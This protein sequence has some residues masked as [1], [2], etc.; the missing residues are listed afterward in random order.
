MR[1]VMRRGL[2]PFEITHTLEQ[3]HLNVIWRSSMKVGDLVRFPGWKDVG[4][5]VREIPG[6]GEVKVVMWS[7]SGLS[8]HAAKDLEVINESR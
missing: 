5:I 6:W 1:L 3:S 4:V 8:S 2:S 7:T